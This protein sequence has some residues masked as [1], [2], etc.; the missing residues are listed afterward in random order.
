[1]IFNTGSPVPAHGGLLRPMRTGGLAQPR[2]A[3]TCGASAAGMLDRGAWE[4]EPLFFG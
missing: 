4:S 3:P 2:Q 1:M